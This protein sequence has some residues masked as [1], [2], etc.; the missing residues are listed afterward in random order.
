MS[1]SFVC[2]ST[3]VPIDVNSSISRCKYFIKSVFFS[4]TQLYKLISSSDLSLI[5]HL[6]VVVSKNT[7][8]PPTK[9]SI[10]RPEYLGVYF[11]IIGT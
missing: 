4:L 1:T 3:N 2:L 7:A 6:S 8:P 9:G 11:L 10:N 5:Q